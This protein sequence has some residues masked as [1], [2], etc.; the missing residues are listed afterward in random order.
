MDPVTG[1]IIG[2]VGSELV[3]GLFGSSSAKK[4]NKAAAREAE[5]A[6]A[7]NREMMQN[8]HQWEVDD[9][10]KAGLNPILSAGGSPSIGSS[11]QAPVMDEG[12][13]ASSSAKGIGRSGMEAQLLKA[14][15][16]SLK[17]ASAKS[18]AEAALTNTTNT[19]K[20]VLTSLYELAGDTVQGVTSKIPAVVNS[21]KKFGSD[22]A[23][24]V[25][26]FFDPPNPKKY[27]YGRGSK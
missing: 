7:F 13:A 17:S 23:D 18:R 12:Q 25:G 21:A 4:A 2:Q 5:R 24:K 10:R 11:P 27:K 20:S 14:Q 19:Q 8:R 15:I 22:T 9:L 6:R 3:G 16:E 1:A 26:K